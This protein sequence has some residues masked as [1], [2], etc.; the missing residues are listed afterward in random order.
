MRLGT[1]N[2]NKTIA[3]AVLLVIGVVLFMRTLQTPAPGAAAAPAAAPPR[4][5]TAADT[6]RPSTRERKNYVAAAITPTLDPR[7]R[8]DL[9]KGSEDTRYEGSGRNIFAE[10]PVEI[11][12]PVQAACKGDP[13]CRAGKVVASSQPPPGPPP[14]PPIDLKSYGWASKP[15]EQKRI[16]LSRGQ[17]VFVAAEGDI[18]A[19]RYKV[20]K[21]EGN[22][23]VI[24]D[25]L[26]NNRQS[27]PLQS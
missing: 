21:I 14:P 20:V 25:L 1:E 2:R 5:S 4:A 26:S 15:G 18:V 6:P 7:L 27:I 16:F 8:L 3:A 10:R 24:E 12:T 17:D 11:P 22:Q 9:L 13:K 23:V 19:R